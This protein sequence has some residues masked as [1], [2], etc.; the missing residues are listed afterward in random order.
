MLNGPAIGASPTSAHRQAVGDVLRRL[1]ARPA[2]CLLRAFRVQD[3]AFALA[4]LLGLNA[5]ALAAT[6]AN[7]AISNTA[8]A[9]YHVGANNFS[10]TSTASVNTAACIA[11]GVKIELLQYVPAAGAAL[12]PVGSRAEMVQPTGYTPNGAL[13]GPFVA[14]RQLTLP[15]QLASTPLPASL[16]LAPLSDA[17]GKPNGSYS[18]NDPVFVRV[19]S[20]DA[21]INPAVADTVSVTLTT[22]GGD[23]EVLQ[24]TETVSK[25]CWNI[26]NISPQ[27]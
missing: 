2:R 1:A 3:W 13:T 27:Q 16:L 26:F 12:T 9:S 21:N 18:R 14:L 8:T 25:R 10:A 7:T 19:V 11:V 22:S 20:Y 23:S 15:G 24:L 17:A 5:A 6:P 4:T